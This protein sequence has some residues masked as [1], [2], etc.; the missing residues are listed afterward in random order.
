MTEGTTSSRQ[1]AESG[2]DIYIGEATKVLPWVSSRDTTINPN[3]VLSERFQYSSVGFV[4]RITPL[5]LPPCPFGCSDDGKKSPE[6][7]KSIID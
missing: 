5:Q 6:T 4:P 1:L 7:I 3:I 2:D